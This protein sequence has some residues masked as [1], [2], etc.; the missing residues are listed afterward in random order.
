MKQQ[1]HKKNIRDRERE[2]KNIKKEEE[3]GSD[4]N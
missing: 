3:I 4:Q 2:K 1:I